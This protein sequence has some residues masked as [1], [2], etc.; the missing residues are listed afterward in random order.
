MG[1]W[2]WYDF[3]AK[4][5]DDIKGAGKA[6]LQNKI[7]N[8]I[9]PIIQPLVEKFKSIGDKAMG[10]IQKIPGYDKVTKIIQV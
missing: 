10:L 4:S 7:I 8:V 1:H 9:Q 3:A 6:F 5:L 2:H